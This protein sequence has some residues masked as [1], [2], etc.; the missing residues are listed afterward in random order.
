[1]FKKKV[2]KEVEAEMSEEVK[3]DPVPEVAKAVPK[4]EEKPLTMQESFNAVHNLCEQYSGLKSLRQIFN[5]AIKA[6]KIVEGLNAEVNHRQIIIAN[7]EKSMQNL[8]NQIEVDYAKHR[9]HQVSNKAAIE[10]QWKNHL[11]RLTKERESKIGI[12]EEEVRKILAESLKVKEIFGKRKDALEVLNKQI[13]IREIHLQ[14]IDEQISKLK[15]A[16]A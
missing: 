13:E 7:L 14:T 16:L 2:K 9:E 5:S 10:E 1:M 4:V 3:L 8:T 12:L 11:A 6:E 15:A